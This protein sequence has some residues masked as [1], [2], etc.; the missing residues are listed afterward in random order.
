MTCTPSTTSL[1]QV[2]DPTGVHFD[3]D[4]GLPTTGR[5]RALTTTDLHPATQF[6]FSLGKFT[7]GVTT[8]PAGVKAWS[9]GVVSGTVYV[10]GV[11]PLPLGTSLNG[12]NYSTE[13]RLNA[14]ITISGAPGAYGLLMWEN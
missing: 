14:A 12:G 10:D 1:T 8:V 3:C 11:G 9:I 4:T 2:W 5:W 6:G 13:A 7:S